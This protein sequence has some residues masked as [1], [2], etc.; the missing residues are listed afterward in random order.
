MHLVVVSSI[1][2]IV[3]VIFLFIK[4]QT[5]LANLESNE[6]R[7][8]PLSIFKADTPDRP[9]K[10]IDA[11]DLFLYVIGISFWTS[12][13]VLILQ[14]YSGDFNIYIPTSISCFTIGLVYL[15]H[16]SGYKNFSYHLL[17]ITMNCLNL[18]MVVIGG[19]NFQAIYTLYIFGLIFTFI[20]FKEINILLIYMIMIVISQIVILYYN[21]DANIT[22]LNASIVGDGICLMAVNIAIFLMCY[23][24]LTNLEKAREH[25]DISAC[26]VKNQKEELL[27]KRSELNQY[28]ESN[29]QL[30]NYTHLAAHELK[31]PLK[32]VKGFADIL[33]VR[34]AS[35]LDN[36]EKEMFNFISEKT[37]KMDVLLNDLTLLGKVSQAELV[38]EHIKLRDLF[39]DI[40]IDRSDVIA[41]T[42]ANIEL[43]F[44]VAT[45]V[46]QYGLIKQ[47]FSNL[48]GNA[49]K[50]TDTSR[51]PHIQVL[52]NE[53]IDEI[54]FKIKDNGIGI[55][56]EHK[57]KI[58]Q[59]FGRLHAESEFKGSGIGLSIS[60]KIVDLHHGTIS[61]E[62]SDLG[63]TCFVVRIP[64]L[65]F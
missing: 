26:E 38:K 6:Q 36:K 35:K 22:G 37:D 25:L 9:I 34:V 58:F 50:F 63:G 16:R 24:Y 14:V 29:V 61:V 13:L 57:H 53:Q 19:N 46:G 47:L 5:P 44:K 3:T 56:P 28:I 41:T 15:L 21:S 59:I 4:K 20:Y 39:A 7:Y 60:K 42:Q 43:D 18:Y 64:K 23:F 40:L 11:Q 8:S 12:C 51:K 54:V 2:S 52:A 30:E 62:E 31:A 27:E 45:M 10:S 1:F 49:L 48:I 55:K 65:D 33:K 32:S 17:M